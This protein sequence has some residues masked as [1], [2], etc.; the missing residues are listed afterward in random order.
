M[1]PDE[2]L[3]VEDPDSG[4]RKHVVPGVLRVRDVRVGQPI[5]ISPGALPRF[6]DQFEN[7]YGARGKAKTIIAA[8]C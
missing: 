4:E 1:L 3:W 6:L 2:L 8:V 7:T 5:L